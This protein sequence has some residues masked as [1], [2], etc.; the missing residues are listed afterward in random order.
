MGSVFRRD[1]MGF[2]Y[3]SAAYFVFAV[4]ALLS[5]VLAVF[6]GMYFVSPGQSMLP[7]FAFQ[8]QVLAVLMPAVTM[9]SWAEERK[10]G[11]F[12]NLL[13]YPV[14]SW[15]LVLA[16]FYAAFT[17]GAFML[18]FSLPLLLTTAFYLTPDYG[19]I[20]C[21][22]VGTLGTIAVLAAAGC[23]FSSLVSLPSVSYL[24]GLAAGVLWINFNWGGFASALWPDAPFYFENALDFGGN[25]QN[26]LNGQLV[27]AG[28]FYFAGLCMLLLF[29]NWLAVA[30]R[31]TE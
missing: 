9:R 18:V 12:E 28:V 23:F 1:L 8:P 10:N 31:R 5:A 20:F 30:G 11:T 7:Y 27:P 19:N 3:G 16:K 21:C 4:Y 13:T 22:Y 17:V 2:F 6:W 14:S 26:F 24:L 29:L 25:Y 15:S